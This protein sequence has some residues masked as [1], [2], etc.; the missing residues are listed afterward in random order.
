MLE[1]SEILK[2]YGLKYIIIYAII[3][4]SF[5]EKRARWGRRGA[6]VS[7]SLELASFGQKPWK[8]RGVGGYS[9][10]LGDLGRT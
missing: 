6:F 4:N 2:L 8:L 3:L 10:K 1:L 5:F 7:K 9:R